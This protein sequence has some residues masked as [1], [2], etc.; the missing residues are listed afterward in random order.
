MCRREYCAYIALTFCRGEKIVS[1][2]HSVEPED[3]IRKPKTNCDAMMQTLFLDTFPWLHNTNEKQKKFTLW[4]SDRHFTF[5]TL[6]F[7][8]NIHLGRRGEITY[9]PKR[10]THYTKPHHMNQCCLLRNTFSIISWTN[11]LFPKKN[12][13]CPVTMK[14]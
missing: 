11:L 14:Q 2:G 10:S 3:F 13:M 7:L 9:C 4:C 12:S 5:F 8:Q 1:Q 6:A